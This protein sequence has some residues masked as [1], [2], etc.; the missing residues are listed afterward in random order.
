MKLSSVGFAFSGKASVVEVLNEQNYDEYFSTIGDSDLPIV[1]GPWISEV[2]FELL[3][4]IP[5][6][7][8]IVEAYRLD[9]RRIYIAVSYTHLTLP[10]KA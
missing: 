9:K 1:M 5:F 2:G 10:T 7:N 4:W 3:Y 8:R 6:L